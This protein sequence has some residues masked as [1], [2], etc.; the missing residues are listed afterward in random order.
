MT[1]VPI[2]IRTTLVPLSDRLN[3]S[4]VKDIYVFWKKN[5]QKCS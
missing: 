1:F 4:F 2:K 3:L 5:D